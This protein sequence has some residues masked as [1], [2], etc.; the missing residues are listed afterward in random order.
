MPCTNPAITPTKSSCLSA[1]T[2]TRVDIAQPCPA[3]NIAGPHAVIACICKLSVSRYKPTDFPPSS[4]CTRFSVFDAAAM[5]AFPV[6]TLPVNEIL[7]IR[8]SS[9]S[10]WLIAVDWPVTQLTTPGGRSAS[11][12]ISAKKRLMSGPYGDDLKTIVQ[13]V[14]SAGASFCMATNTGKFQVGIMPHTPTGW[15]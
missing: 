15:R 13:P 8:G 11:A 5:I 6:A 14:A 2:S 3:W 1:G 9:H 4:R 12:Q 10:A 7:S